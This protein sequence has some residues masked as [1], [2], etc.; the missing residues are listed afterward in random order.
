MATLA[1]VLAFVIAGIG[2][3]LVAMS[4]GPNGI[5]L[6]SEATR[7]GR[8]ATIAL[9]AVALVALGIG[10][11][12]GVMSS[13]ADRSD[14]PESGISLSKS[15]EHGRELFG[16]NCSNCHTLKGANAVAEVGPDLDTLKPPKSLVLDAI[17]KGRARGS[18]QMAANL[19]QGK[20]ADDVA[21]FVA[22]VAG[23]IAEQ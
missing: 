8:R 17:H 9:F 7:G 6:L 22:K 11:P 21:D 18:G 19:V 4:G 14:V 3:V 15:Q 12:F 23:K 20:D 16:R 1:L 13:V 5:K 2:V 10:I